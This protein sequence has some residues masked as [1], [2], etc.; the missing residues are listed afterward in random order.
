MKNSTHARNPS[1]LRQREICLPS[2]DLGR[3]TRQAATLRKTLANPEVRA[4]LSAAN[5]K[6]WADPARHARASA[7]I[8]R[9]WAD[10]EVRVRRVT[11]IK[12]AWKTERREAQRT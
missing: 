4:R 3:R 12:K 10:P 7:A 5:K 6:A 9:S 8:R 1:K 2:A 11:G